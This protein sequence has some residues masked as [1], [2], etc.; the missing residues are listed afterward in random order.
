MI[1]CL[2]FENLTDFIVELRVKVVFSKHYW[3]QT[4]LSCNVFGLKASSTFIP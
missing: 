2:Q 4:C 3:I 1:N